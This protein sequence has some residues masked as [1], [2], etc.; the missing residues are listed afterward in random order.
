MER[1]LAVLCMF[2]LP[3]S[4]CQSS[5]GGRPSGGSSAGILGGGESSQPINPAEEKQY[6]RALLKC[7]KTGGSR[8]VKIKG[9]LRC[10]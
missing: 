9:I 8:I 4:A 1:L 7:Y 10:Y 6:K 5:G 2:Y 3:V